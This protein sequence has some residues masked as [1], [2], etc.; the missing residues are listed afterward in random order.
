MLMNSN[1]LVLLR[2]GHILITDESQRNQSSI[3]PPFPG[4]WQYNE[5]LNWIKSSSVHRVFVPW[6]F[7]TLLRFLS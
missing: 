4:R 1:D 6:Y 5:L 7:T 3:L 2:T